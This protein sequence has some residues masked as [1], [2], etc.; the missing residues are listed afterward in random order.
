MSGEDD[1]MDAYE[2]AMENES[3]FKQ[4]QRQ[5]L[6]RGE[7]AKGAEKAFEQ[8][9][10]PEIRAELIIVRDANI[11]LASENARLREEVARLTD[12]NGAVLATNEKLCETVSDFRLA[13]HDCP[14]CTR[15]LVARVEILTKE[16]DEARNCECI[17]D[18]AHLMEREYR[19]TTIAL[20]GEVE[21]LTK[22]RDVFSFQ[23]EHNVQLY[24]MEKKSNERLRE[25]LE[26]IIATSGVVKATVEQ[27]ESMSLDIHKI[28][29]EAL[30]ADEG[31]L[32]VTKN[33]P[34]DKG[35]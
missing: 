5:K 4:R 33:E 35:E 21:R 18:S 20:R 10:P 15:A 19:E 9:N 16:R 17:D 26:D 29:Y 14:D 28:A 12:E 7:D 6:T 32:D 31:K 25:A 1:S 27:H 13:L 11:R 3:P 23:S 34:S 30:S 24:R 8:I 22:E 2:D